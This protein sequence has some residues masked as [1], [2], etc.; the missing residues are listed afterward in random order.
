MAEIVKTVLVIIIVASLLEMLLPESSLKPFVSFTM[1]LFV[2]I[3]ILNPVLNFA[4]KDREF[5]INLWDYK[6]DQA[7]EEEM[8]DKGMDIN[9]QVIQS[10]D[11][12]I[13]EKLQGQISAM[14][15]LVPG[16]QEVDARIKK[17]EAGTADKFM[18]LVRVEKNETD[19]DSKDVEV[20][21]SGAE[22]KLRQEEQERIKEKI[23]LLIDNMYGIKAGLIEI[24]FEGGDS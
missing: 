10:N 23:L 14:T 22:K 6:Y 9:Q 3:A 15:S 2:L 20:F 24:K 7:L 18:L 4:F 1:G 11:Q 21:G 12:Q 5:A 17:G 8:L 13:Q 19:D 16:V